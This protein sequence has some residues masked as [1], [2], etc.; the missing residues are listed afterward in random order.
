MSKV[1]MSKIAR[2]DYFEHD[3][4]KT[5]TQ[6]L[7]ELKDSGVNP[8]PNVYKPE[9]KAGALLK[10]YESAP[11]GT[12]EDAEH[13]KTPL[14]KIAGRLVL[15]RAMGKN[16]F[17]QIQ[18]DTSRIQVM[19]NRDKTSLDGYK[20]NPD[21]PESLSAF[22]MIEKK[23]D[24][25][26]I[27]GVEGYLFR[28]GK[29]ELTVFANEVTLLCKTLLPLADKHGGLAD[30]ETRYRKRWLDLITNP[31]VAMQFKKR[32]ELLHEIRKYF[33]ENMFM[34]V[35]TPVLQSIY[36]GAEARPF[37]TKLNALDQEMFMR[38]S[39]EPSLKKLIVGGMD[40]VFEMGRVFRNEGIDRSHNPEFT[41]VEAYASYWDYND[42]MSFVENLF[43]KLA[44]HLRGTSIVPVTDPATGITTEIDMK[45]PWIRLTMKDAIRKYGKLEPDTLSDEEIRDF[46][47][48][49]GHV[50]P[51]KVK[52][53]SRG[54][55]IA[56][57]FEVTAEEHL[58]QPHHIIDHPIETTPL[59]KLHR[60]PAQREAGIVERF[61]S[62]ILGCEI[63]NAYTELNDPVIQRDLLEAQA[64]R[65]DAGD[66]EASPLD[67]EFLEAI[68]QGM[69][70][71]GG[72]GIGIDRLVMMLC[73]Q[74]SI[75]DVLFFPWMK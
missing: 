59:C 23:I 41:M 75:R 57:L 18:D 33:H 1:L 52:G 35:E 37:L 2:P 70:P 43:E 39:L 36:G 48:K 4:F 11:V 8:Y 46:L 14:V 64:A 3:E 66:E 73:N 56:A 49:S 74:H 65:R 60:D 63:C 30:K 5:R 15:F 67:E 19:F 38:I 58:V 32:S 51:K 47:L 50:D 26:D 72:I 24:L 44:I 16:A 42:M 55:L 69:P 40:R 28:T 34:E 27:I 61:E 62:F 10:E 20:Q 12:S 7:Q 25:G 45:A 54:L 31:D 21:D 68:C 71:T 22:K 17:A 29:G 53:L 6:K 13:A 9:H